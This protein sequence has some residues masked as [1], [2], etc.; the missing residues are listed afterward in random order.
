MFVS[1]EPPDNWSYA[2]LLGAYLGDGYLSPRGQLVVVCDLQYPEVIEDT[3]GAMILTSLRLHV[4]IHPHPVYRCARVVC[5]WPGWFTAF[6]QHGLGRKHER[7]IVLEDWQASIVDEFRCSV[8]GGSCTRTAAGPS[9]VSR[10]SCQA[11]A[12]PSTSIRGG[13]SRTSPRTS[14]NCSVRTANRSAC[15][16]RS[17]TP[18]TSRSRIGGASRSWTSTWGRRH[19]GANPRPGAA[20]A[21]APRPRRELL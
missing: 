17:R 11:G 9:T 16:G 6:P 5:S 20:E 10:R 12:L 21:R 3:R 2:Y 7:P 19:D 15:A 14:G 4:G 13:S 8:S 18:G 1:W